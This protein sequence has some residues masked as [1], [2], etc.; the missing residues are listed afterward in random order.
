MR[1]GSR[2]AGE[3][4]VRTAMPE[5]WAAKKMNPERGP[6]SLREDIPFLSFIFAGPK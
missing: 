6:L 5:L 4:T 1:F 2:L 3:I